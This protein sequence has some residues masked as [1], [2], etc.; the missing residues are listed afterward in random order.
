MLIEQMQDY[1]HRRAAE[2]DTSM[3]YDDPLQLQAL[4]PVVE[5]LKRRAEGR[6][7]LELACGP[8]F[9]TSHIIESAKFV[10]ATDF[11][12]S[13]LDQALKKNL[14]PTKVSF[15]QADAYDLRNIK[16]EFDLL[17]A[18]D[19]LAHVPRSK[20]NNFLLAIG[21]RLGKAK[22]VTFVDQ[23]PKPHSLTGVFDDKGN[24]LQRR[25]LK[26]GKTFS[27][28]KHYFSDQDY[29][30]LFDQYFTNLSIQRF[31]ECHRVIVSAQIR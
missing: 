29:E 30:D 20:M 12:Q 22:Q 16:G 24:H 3:G 11:N 17:L 15:K 21:E 18:V 10:V 7:V 28:I 26:S 4:E 19:W 1:Y 23:L 6:T 2:Y 31:D 5:K 27:V 8:G 9:W 14:P 25:T 13:T